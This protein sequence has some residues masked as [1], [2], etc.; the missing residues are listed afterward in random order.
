MV[1]QLDYGIWKANFGNTAGV[2]ASS[3]NQPI[4]EPST[5]IQLLLGCIVALACLH[6]VGRC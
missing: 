4:P 6:R 3:A 5:A 1:D 2:T